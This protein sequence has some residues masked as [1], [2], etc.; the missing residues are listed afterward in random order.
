MNPQKKFKGKSVTLFMQ[1]HSELQK[2]KF[3]PSFT[4]KHSKDL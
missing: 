3:S 2:G 4:Y 1:K